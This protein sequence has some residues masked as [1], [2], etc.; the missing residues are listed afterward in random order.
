MIDKFSKETFQNALFNIHPGYKSLGILQGEEVYSIPVNNHTRLLI[1]SSIN[2]AGFAAESGD[3]SIRLW[4]EIYQPSYRDPK[5]SDWFATTQK[6][7]A[8]TQRTKGWESRLKSKISVLWDRAVKIRTAPTTCLNCP[9]TFCKIFIVKKNNHNKGRPFQTCK[10]CSFFQWLDRGNPPLPP[11]TDS[12]SELISNQQSD[13][14]TLEKEPSRQDIIFT[15][16]PLPTPTPVFDFDT[17]FLE[18]V[19]ELL[20]FLSSQYQK[21]IYDFVLNGTGHGIVF[22]VAGCAKTTSI[23]EAYRLLREKKPHLSIKILAF[24]SHI[25]KELRAKN[26]TDAQTF[27]SLGMANIKAAMPNA[28]FNKNKVYDICDK[29]VDIAWEEKPQISKIIGLLKSNL[30]INPT[31][32]D[33]LFLIDNFPSIGLIDE[34]KKDEIARISIRVFEACEKDTKTFDF[35]DQV[36]WCATGKVS[37]QQFDFVF[38]DEC[39]D[40]DKAQIEMAIKSLTENGRLLLI[41]DSEQAIYT[42]RGAFVGIMDFMKERLQATAL[43]LTISYRAPL[44]IVRRINELHPHI[45]FEAFEGAKEGSVEYI[46]TEQF[47]DQ[48]QPNDVVL[49]RTNAPLVK[50][51]FAL[52]SQGVKA[53]ILGKNIGDGILRLVKKRANLHRVRKL[54]NSNEQLLQLLK[55]LQIYLK[56]QAP[57]LMSACRFGALQLLQ[58]QID[59]IIAISDDCQTIKE[60]QNKITSTFSDNQEGVTFSTIHKAKGLEWPVVYVIGEIGPHPMAKTPEDRESERRLQYVRDTRAMDKLIFVGDS[61]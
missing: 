56:Q 35:S 10:D 11:F 38:V 45:I 58:D 3:D 60:L 29:E 19:P 53:I 28:E 15:P 41:G 32:K 36:Y 5:V 49:C 51:C 42:F 61:P 31:I 14:F 48:V 34:N 40:L 6:I 1:R 22:G 23:I 12:G 33:A 46:N 8:L 7:D 57:K 43:P 30:I 16:I 26:V 59:T 21:A 4:L 27:G 54:T 39:Q 13:K 37:C 9:N 17:A 50:P 24:N 47:L 2:N 25:A 20:K 55:E 44:A 18:L 52:I